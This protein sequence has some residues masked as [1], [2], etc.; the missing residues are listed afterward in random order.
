MVQN[1]AKLLVYRFDTWPLY[2][3]TVLATRPMKEGC[4]NLASH[5][6][7]WQD[8]LREGWGHRSLG[9]WA[10]ARRAN[11]GRLC[12]PGHLHPRLQLG[13]ATGRGGGYLVDAVRAHRRRPGYGLVLY[14]KTKRECSWS[15]GH[16]RERGGCW[17][18][19]LCPP[20]RGCY[21][22]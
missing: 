15:S 5:R 20:T 6:W 21:A 11:Q 12:P 17:P 7:G 9:G 16:K 1:P 14:N 13:N 3:D 19:E 2:F 22:A 10:Y 4:W 8:A 18:D